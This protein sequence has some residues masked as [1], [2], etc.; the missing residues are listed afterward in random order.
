MVRPV[1]VGIDGS[2]ESLA[3][4]A[5]AGQEA[6]R[7]GLPLHLVYALEWRTSN[8]QFSPGA[9]AQREW[10][11]SRI[12][13]A[14][15][16]LSETHPE[17]EVGVRRPAGP[18]AKALIDIAGESEELVLGSRGLGVL[19][20]FLLGTVSLTVIAHASRPVVAVREAGTGD[21]P[22]VVGLGHEGPYGPLLDF[23]FQA[24]AGR[25]TGVQAVG[26]EPTAPA[27]KERE[28][29][30]RTLGPWRERWPQ[31]E[32]EE[33]LPTGPAVRQLVA[34]AT[35]AALLVVG[36]RVRRPALGVRLGP[37]AHGV[38]HHAPCPVAV[39]PHG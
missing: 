18:P 19:E 12:E 36:R 10:V 20:G 33:R 5:W 9:S 28:P 8:L 16:E 32:V 26:A 39:V 13:V 4:A 21:G 25:G 1:S 37:V 22:V 11:E 6:A 27:A 34:E 35:D 7:R 17:L 31:V 38:L 30:A 15:E 2:A 24:A 29:L 3:A 23:A 14:Q